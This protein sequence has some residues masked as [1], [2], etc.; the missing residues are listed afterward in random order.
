[1]LI[2][3]ITFYLES[4]KRLV[5]PQLGAFIVK[6]PGER[7]LFSELMRRDDGVLRGLMRAEG[8]SELEA[9]GEIDRFVFEV[10]HAVQHNREYPLG[11]F[12]VFRSGPNNTIAFEYTPLRSA[13]S[14]V[15]S[16]AET[17]AEE[18]PQLH[19]K[20]ETAA[21]EPRV[22]V[23][24]KM[25]PEPYVRGLRYGKPPKN[26]DAYAYVGPSKGRRMDRFLI[27]AIVAAVIAVAAIAFGYFRESRDEKAER[28]YME[29]TTLQGQ[30]APAENPTQ[31]ATE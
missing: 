20:E 24:P 29:Q 10:R 14:E 15:H 22:S 11:E 13:Q 4:N 5:I 3:I 25:H 8:V 21:A 26:T 17:P 27:V 23:S 12:G 6:V 1:M 18:S 30:P 31:T 16:Q 19:A 9:A 28:E 7:V 2:R